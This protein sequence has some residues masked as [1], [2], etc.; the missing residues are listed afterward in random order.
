M[1]EAP[2]EDSPETSHAFGRFSS[3]QALDSIGLACY[4]AWSFVFW[5]GSVLFGDQFQVVSFDGAYLLQG[6]FS[7]LS[8]LLL[9]FSVRSVK[10][11]RKSSILLIL[12]ALV[13]SVAI[14]FAALAGYRGA[15]TEFFFVGFALSGLGSCLRLGWEEHLSVKGVKTAAIGIGLA[16]LVGFLLF[17]LLSFLPPLITLIIAAVLPFISC[18][19]LMGVNRKGHRKE[20]VLPST[21]ER[22]SLK[23]LFSRIPWKLLIAIALAYFSY[24]ATR[25]EGVAGGLAVEEELGIVFAGGPALACLLGIGLAYYFYRKSAVMAFYIAFP[26]MAAAALLPAAIDPFHGGTA[27]WITLVGAELVKYLVWFL[28]IDGIMKD[29]VSALLCVAL[30]RFAQWSGSCL[31]QLFVGNVPSQEAVAIGILVSLIAALLVI[32][33]SPIVKRSSDVAPLSEG[34]LLDHKVQKAAVEFGLSPREK[35]VLVI[36]VTGRSGAYIEK[37]LFI[38]KSTVKT[39]LNHI[40]AKTATANR[41]ELFELLDSLD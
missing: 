34:G 23:T 41:E 3:K 2:S 9:V 31:G 5:N 27:F 25:M 30:M 28:L 19:L 18:A 38:S 17:S 22:D 4:I 39:H 26:L 35:E 6:A 12:F 16:Y 21:S 33:G 11:L 20:A 37:K 32:I 24:G 7:A 13:S 15:P 36:W 1:Q 14:I 29:G 10:S 8:A 40:Y